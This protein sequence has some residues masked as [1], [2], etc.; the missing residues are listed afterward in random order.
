MSNPSILA[1]AAHD[2][3]LALFKNTMQDLRI[4]GKRLT[5]LAL[6][7][8]KNLDLHVITPNEWNQRGNQLSVEMNNATERG[9]QRAPY[10]RSRL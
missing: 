10:R 1:L 7:G 6:Q 4:E 8:F 9:S 2:A 3:A 5:D